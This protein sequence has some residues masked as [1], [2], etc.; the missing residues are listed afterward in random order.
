MLPPLSKKA[1]KTDD[2]CKAGWYLARL[3]VQEGDSRDISLGALHCQSSIAYQGRKQCY[4]V[5]KER[6]ESGLGR[7]ILGKL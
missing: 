2:P 6:R 7:S 5:A 1:A 3:S 4:T